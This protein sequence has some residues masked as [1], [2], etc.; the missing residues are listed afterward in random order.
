MYLINFVRLHINGT[1]FYREGDCSTFYIIVV[2]IIQNIGLDFFIAAIQAI[3]EKYVV[4]AQ[5]KK[6]R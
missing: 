2:F 6:W 4:Y 1:C 5:K 3:N